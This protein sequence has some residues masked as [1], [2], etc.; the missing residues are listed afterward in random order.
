MKEGQTGCDCGIF[1]A[2]ARWAVERG[3]K[4]VRR[5]VYGGGMMIKAERIDL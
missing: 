1:E 2:M 4:V 5:S 3:E